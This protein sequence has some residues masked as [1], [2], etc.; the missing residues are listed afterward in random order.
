MGKIKGKWFGFIGSGNDQNRSSALGSGRYK[1]FSHVSLRTSLIWLIFFSPLL[2]LLSFII[3]IHIFWSIP[4]FEELENP[5]YNWA[6]FVFDNEGKEFGKYYVENRE[7]VQYSEVNPMVVS[8]LIATEDERFYQHSGIDFKALWR[9]GIKTV[10]MGEKSAGGGSTITQQL[11]KLLYKRPPL[12]NLTSWKQKFALAEIKMKEWITAVKL[13]KSYTKEEIIA[14]YLNKFEFVNGA[15][16]IQSAA[17]IY[18]NV[19]QKDLTVD[20]AALLIGMLQ[21]PSLYNPNRFPD[22]VLTRRNTVL[23]LLRNNNLID[24]L[25]FD[26]LAATPI[27]MENF[28]QQKPIEGPAPYFRYQLVKE[29]KR[30]FDENDVKKPGGE[31]YNVFTDGLKIYTTIDLTYQKLAEE[32]VSEHMGWLQKRY[33]N[34]WGSRDPWTYKGT[35]AEIA[36]R[37]KNLNARIRES[38][39]YKELRIKSL[40]TLVKEN[41]EFPLDDDVL[42]VLLLVDEGESSIPNLAKEGKLN[43]RFIKDYE[44]FLHGKTWPALRSEYLEFKKEYERVFNSVVPSQIFDHEKGTIIKEMS[45][46]D[47]VKYHIRQLQNGLLAVE[48]I[49]GQIKAWVGGIDF[50]YFKYDHITSPRQIGSIIKPF[51]FTS[52]MQDL[53][54]SP[55]QTYNDVPYTIEVGEGD[56]NLKEV[57]KPNNSTET[58]TSNP[59]NLY[60]GL[61]Y[62]KNSITV[63]L[64][65]EMGTTEY[66]RNLLDKVGLNKND[67]VYNGQPLVPK[68]PAIALGAID[69]TLFQMVG[70]YTTFANGG[71]YSKPIFITKIEDRFGNVIYRDRSLKS[72]AIEP[73][74]NSV[75]LDMLQNNC[76]RDFSF[77]FK[78]KAGGK[79]G[80]TN[81]YIDG[82]F[83]GITPEL[84]VGVWTGGDERYVRFL[85]IDNGQGFVMARPVFERFIQKLEKLPVEKFNPNAKFPTPH[86]DMKNLTSC[87]KYK[88]IPPAEE[89]KMR[90]Q[91]AR[92]EQAKDTLKLLLNTLF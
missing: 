76:S 36:L 3:Y 82:W 88:T 72:Y 8:A 1:W 52:A 17:N 9:V 42:D 12:R 23:S 48:P 74:Y 80:T 7:G 26:S 4:S 19:D 13:E 53:G 91:A 84:V 65:K 51:V 6:S 45:P 64:M 22:R 49:T 81:D 60:H 21:N 63:K 20:Q 54:I 29:I 31:D 89:R 10:I 79:T 70:A 2:L 15:H 33:W 61:L 62:S 92:F 86:P 46:L 38:D 5:Q 30:L 50:N 39:R 85:S 67:T 58:F 69:A 77:R 83:M 68:V 28:R 73:L 34:E 87:E 11:A 78:S 27:N 57:W 16:G 47:S 35:A 75:I 32:A 56:F 59:Y 18:F 55:C 71:T 25:T 66:V 43:P 14:L 41:I 44:E 24:K 37:Y 40:P 90:A